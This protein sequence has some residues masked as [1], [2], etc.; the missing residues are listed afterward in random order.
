MIGVIML[1]RTRLILNRKVYRGMSETRGR[2]NEFG[3]RYSIMAGLI[4]RRLPTDNYL[5]LEKLL[6]A[7]A[8]RRGGFTLTKLPMPQL[9]V[10]IPQK[11]I[12]GI[13]W[14][15]FTQEAAPHC[16][17]SDVLGHFIHAYL[18]H[19]KN[20]LDLSG[21]SGFPEYMKQRLQLLGQVPLNI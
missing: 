5:A 6:V 9:I 4:L 11:D 21:V 19:R 16:S 18:D 2:L 20:T 15:S 8:K 12:P 7:I 17:R 13:E 14:N 1:E 3:I 10:G